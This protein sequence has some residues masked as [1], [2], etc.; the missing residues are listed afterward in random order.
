MALKA[1]T[2]RF[3]EDLWQLLEQEAARQ[4]VSAAQFLRDCA[5]LRLGQLSGRRGDDAARETVADLARRSLE[6]RRVYGGG[7]AEQLSEP[8]RLTALR[9]TGLLD[10]ATDPG[11]ESLAA[12]TAKTLHA[13]IA[14]ITLVEPERQFFAAQQGLPE[15]WRSR[16]QTPLSHSFCQEVVLAQEPLVVEDGRQ[17]P[18]LRGNAA[19]ADLGV[20]AYAG[21]PLSDEQGHVLGALCAI[22]PSPHRWEE[23]ELELLGDLAGS[24]RAYLNGL[25]S[26]ARA[27][28]S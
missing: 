20:V 16:R 22:H 21:L 24:A 26:G 1:T 14:L 19:I 5:L 2:V 23:A 15:P 8:G 9:R 3:G 27:S 4:G 7:R 11:L 10:R 17:D 13:P 6:Q 18:H 25:I 28:A 12:L